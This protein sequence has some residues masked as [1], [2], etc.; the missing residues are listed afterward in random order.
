MHK[1]DGS[2]TGELRFIWLSLL[3][4]VLDQLSK[5]F[6]S[7]ELNLHEPLAVLPMFNLTLAYNTGAAFSF[8]QTAG[9][10]QQWLFGGIALVVSIILIIWLKNLP[11]HAYSHA[12]ALALILGGALGNLMDRLRL[13]YVV[14]FIQLYV[15]SWYWPTFNLADSAIT[16]GAILLALSVLRKQPA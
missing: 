12:I 10:W 8:L 15:H 9:G 6:A 3:V 1:S 2:K 7:A 11:R 4:I 5:Y 14:D 16:L 13:G